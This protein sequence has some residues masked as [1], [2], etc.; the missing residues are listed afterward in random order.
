MPRTIF[1]TPLSVGGC[2]VI[3]PIIPIPRKDFAVPIVDAAIITN[4]RGLAR[5]ARELAYTGH[6]DKEHA[7]LSLSNRLDHQVGQLELCAMVSQVPP[8]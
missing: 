7:L 3:E 2:A 5:E 1:P 4:L 6:H 8:R